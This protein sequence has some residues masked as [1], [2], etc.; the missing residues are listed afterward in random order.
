MKVRLA[1]IVLPGNFSTDQFHGGY[2]FYI[3]ATRHLVLIRRIYT[4][5]IATIMP[6]KWHA[7]NAGRIIVRQVKITCRLINI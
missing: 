3:H 1:L 4:L 7:K 2:A 5:V 6:R